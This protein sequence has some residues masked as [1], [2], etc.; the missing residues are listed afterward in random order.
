MDSKLQD[1]NS[2]YYTSKFIYEESYKK[3]ASHESQNVAS[4][5]FIGIM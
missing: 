3:P 2:K 1:T 5:W 4:L